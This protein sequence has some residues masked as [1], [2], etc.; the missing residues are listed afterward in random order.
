M[1]FTLMLQ[2][3]ATNSLLQAM[4]PDRMRGRVM[5]FYSM[6][7][8]G[9]APFG[10]L[11]AGSLASQIGDPRTLAAVGLICLAGAVAFMMALRSLNLDFAGLSEDMS[12]AGPFDE[13]SHAS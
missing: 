1:G 4:V 8:T 13:P 2:I 3:P 5:S 9:M 11:L 6:G 10:S 7:L 12:G